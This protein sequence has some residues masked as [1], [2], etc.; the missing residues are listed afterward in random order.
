VLQALW[1][2]GGEDDVVALGARTPGGLEADAGDPAD[3][4]DGLVEKLPCRRGRR[5]WAHRER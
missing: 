4:D 1:V 5:D 3:D 2:A